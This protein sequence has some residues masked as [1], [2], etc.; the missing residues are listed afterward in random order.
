MINHLKGARAYLAGNIEY[1]SD[2]KDWREY[3]KKHLN[4]RGI[5]VLSPLDNNFIEYVK[6]DEHSKEYLLNKRKLGDYE[7]V[8]AHMRK[9]VR[10]DLRRVD[11]A[12]FVIFRLEVNKPTFG[13]LHEL[14]VSIAQKKP[15]FL[16][17][18]KSICPLWL[19]GIVSYKHMYDT[20]DDILNDIYKIDEGKLKMDDKYWRLLR[21]ELR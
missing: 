8:S 5:K 20:I 6:E 9:V 10:S 16:L 11:F 19:F 21:E 7:D 15:I 4:K 1:T 3:V 14:I 2:S 13:T 17:V 18:E 12:D